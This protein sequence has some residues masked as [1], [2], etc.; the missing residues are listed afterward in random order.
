[1]V[2]IRIQKGYN[3]NRVYVK[4]KNKIDINNNRGKWNDPQFIQRIPEKLLGNHNLK[5]TTENSH[6]EYCAR[7][8][9]H[10][11]TYTHT[12]T[13]TLQKV[14]IQNTEGLQEITL[15][16]THIVTTE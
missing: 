7:A 3:R 1:M 5:K 11:H 12:H 9:G 8:R 16:E 15:N 2:N 13:H 4:C 10:A 6:N 14:L